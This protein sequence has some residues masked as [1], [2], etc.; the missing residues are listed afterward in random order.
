MTFESLKIE[1]NGD[2][3]LVDGDFFSVMYH[4]ILPAT[5]RSKKAVRP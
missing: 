5:E 3:L 1:K 4:E 2:W